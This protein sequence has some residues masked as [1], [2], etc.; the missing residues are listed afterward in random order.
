MDISKGR[1]LETMILLKRLSHSDSNNACLCVQIRFMTNGRYMN[2]DA[3][4]AI[5]C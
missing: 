3:E 4:G 2:S 1:T 5:R